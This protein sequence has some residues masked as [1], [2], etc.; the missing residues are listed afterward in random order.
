MRIRQ[1]QVVFIV[2]LLILGYLSYD[3][4]AAQDAAYQDSVIPST[5]HKRI[6]TVEAGVTD[7]WRAICG[8]RGLT[9]GL[10]RYGASAPYAVLAEEFGFTVEAV[11]ARVRDWMGGKA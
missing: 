7:P 1:E 11:A 3:L 5:G 8:R 9:I 6:V 10:D 4:F 2:A